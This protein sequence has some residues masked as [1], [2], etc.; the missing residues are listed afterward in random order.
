MSPFWRGIVTAGAFTVG[1]AIVA[2]LGVIAYALLTSDG[3]GPDA[4]VARITQTATASP[5]ATATP[6]PT[7]IPAPPTATPE[8]TPQPTQEPT[9]P[10][11]VVQEPAPIPVEQQPPPTQE[12]PPPPPPT[13]EPPPPTPQPTPLP[14]TP[15]P[16]VAVTP[17]AESVQWCSDARAAADLYDIQVDDA[18][19]RGLSGTEIV[20]ALQRELTEAQ[21]YVATNCQGI[22]LTPVPSQQL[23]TMCSQAGQLKGLA[24]GQDDSASQQLVGR[25][26]AFTARYCGY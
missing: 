19:L 2:L 14:P 10:P 13:E 24:S 22:G 8:A 20:Q 21:T 9:P 1:V 5:T 12:P 25:L 3:S 7:P 16:M 18:A 26:D 17:S 15:P 6:R 11:A 4:E 23:T